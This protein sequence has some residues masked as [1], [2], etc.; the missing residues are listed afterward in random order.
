MNKTSENEG[1]PLISVAMICYNQERY[2]EE[3]INSILDQDYPNL[4]IIISDDCSIDQTYNIA[5]NTIKSRGANSNNVIL[6]RNSTNLGLTRNF[7]KAYENAKGEIIVAASGDDVSKPN[8]VSTIYKEWSLNKPSIVTSLYD[9]IDS[10]GNLIPFD[11]SHQ[12]GNY[13]SGP[14]FNKRNVYFFCGATAAYSAK[15][16]K[17]LNLPDDY[18][19]AEDVA[20]LYQAHLNGESVH[21]IPKSLICYRSHDGSMSQAKTLSIYDHEVYSLQ[22]WKWLVSSLIFLEIR[23]RE[24]NLTK[25]I[26]QN[27]IRRQIKLYKFYRI[28]DKSNIIDRIK[29]LLL[30]R[31]YDEF[32]WVAPRIFGLKAFSNLKKLIRSNKV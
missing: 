1:L 25:Y 7:K 22:Q 19:G 32:R 12:K 24:Q 4:E 27:E 3:A 31:R 26:N 6:Q 13:N 30:C 21:N 8:R 10:S 5:K 17:S 16:I 2:I 18:S 11:A 23:A 28:W 9:M 20:L 14:L 15:F 29:S